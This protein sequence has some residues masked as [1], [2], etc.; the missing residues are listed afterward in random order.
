MTDA[1]QHDV[2]EAEL[3][4]VEEL[5]QRDRKLDKV[6]ETVNRPTPTPPAAH[7][8]THSHTLGDYDTSYDGDSEDV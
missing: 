1:L 5:L 8:P 3:T 7:F 2:N 4:D 6:E